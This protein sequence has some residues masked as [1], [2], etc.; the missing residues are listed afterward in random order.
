MKPKAFTVL[1]LIV[2]LAIIL[3][4]AAILYPVFQRP[5][6]DE[7]RARCQ[8]R[9]KLVAL[10]MTTYAQDYDNKFPL[11]INSRHGL[12]KPVSW[13]GVLET[14]G[15]PIK[16]GSFQ[17]TRDEVATDKQKSSYGYNAW[18]TESNGKDVRHPALV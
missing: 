1:E 10:A 17:C 5:H 12:D 14:Y 13:A 15:L 3:I 8:S 9:L 6:R 11:A 4:L 18:L 16:E 7:G 2:V